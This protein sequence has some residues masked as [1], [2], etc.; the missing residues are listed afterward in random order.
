MSAAGAAGHMTVED[1][2]WYSNRDLPL[3]APAVINSIL[4]AADPV[5]FVIERSPALDLFPAMGFAVD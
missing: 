2:G 3:N 5:T 4:T 1:E